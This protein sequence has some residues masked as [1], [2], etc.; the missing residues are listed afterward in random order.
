MEQYIG[1]SVS[2]GTVRAAAKV[3]LDMDDFAKVEPGDIIVVPKSFPGWIIPL[4]KSS[5]LICEIG[6]VFSHLGILSRELGKPCV[7]GISNICTLIA[8]NDIIYLDG[9]KGEVYVTKQQSGSR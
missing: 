4:I 3:L 8:D 1:I 7:S 6:G 2:G 5:G 9:D